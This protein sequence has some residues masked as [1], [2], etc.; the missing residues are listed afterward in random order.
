M[1]ENRGSNWRDPRPIVERVQV[2]AKLVLHTP[3]HFGAGDPDP[4]SEVDMVLLRD[5]LQGRA[6]LPGAS[7]WVQVRPQSRER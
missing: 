3:A 1:T 7:P 4:L 2:S 6:L 5:P